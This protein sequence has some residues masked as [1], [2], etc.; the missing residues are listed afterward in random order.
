MRSLRKKS[1]LVMKNY[2]TG[3][4]EQTISEQAICS[5]YSLRPCGHVQKCMPSSVELLLQPSAVV[6]V[7][8]AAV[9]RIVVGTRRHHQKDAK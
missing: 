5:R 9:R 6:T 8:P 2:K 4:E 1:E 3:A 7:A